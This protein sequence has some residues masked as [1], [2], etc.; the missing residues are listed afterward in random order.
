MSVSSGQRRNRSI[1]LV[2]LLAACSTDES[3]PPSY[4]HLVEESCSPGST[5]SCYQGPAGSEQLG[6]CRA[7][8]QQCHPSGYGWGVCED[9][10]LPSAEDCSTKADEN[11]DGHTSC[12]QTLWTKRWGV[13]RDEVAHDVATDQE[14]NIY[15]TGYYRDPL[16]LGG[17]EL[18]VIDSSRDVFI[19][20]L[21][22]DGSHQFSR[23]IYSDDHMTARAVAAGPAGQSVVVA[24]FQGK[25]ED[26]GVGTLE[27]AGSYDVLIAYFDAAG[28]PKWAVSAGDSRED[29]PLDVTIDAQGN[30]LVVGYYRGD[31]TFGS[32]ALGNADVYDAFVVKLSSEG[33]HIY[34]RRFG[35]ANTQLLRG[36]TT[37]Q[38]GNAA[39]VGYFY[40]DMKLG[41]LSLTSAGD[42]DIVVTKLDPDGDVLFAQRYGDDEAQTAYQVAF[43]QAG[44]ILFCG[45]F[46]GTVNFGGDSL[47]AQS[48]GAVFVAKLSPTGH[49]T[50]SR[51]LGGPFNQVAYSLAVDSAD[52]VIV[53]GYYEGTASMGGPLLLPTAGL[54]EPNI[55]VAKLE[56]DGDHIWSRGVPVSGNQDAGAV[57]R[58]WRRLAVGNEDRIV[59]A[60]FAE[61]PI[62]L[63]DGL[64]EGA[65]GTDV[66]VAQLQP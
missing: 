15:L 35:G 51:R 2:A 59:L 60:G 47:A 10:V 66:L 29:H 1:W 42:Y 9:Q 36:I 5:R 63:G 21:A 28:S 62:D 12:G 34:S 54:R 48:A 18:A 43:D 8:S 57:A 40:G 31:L 16:D 64:T 33:E 14:G 13:D 39:A 53:T 46:A 25:L 20:K 65:K 38:Q 7:G 11:C 45:G 58:G 49:H 56:A 55:F 17:G 3:A 50:W 6:I 41:G 61:G 23:A 44:N 52:Q 19:A 27:S 26:F 22:S 4:E 32:E 24:S 37:D 30:V